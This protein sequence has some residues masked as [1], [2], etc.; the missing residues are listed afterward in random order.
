MTRTMKRTIATVA[1]GV[2]ASVALVPRAALASGFL[3]YDLSGE[4]I[5]R[6]SAVSADTS[7][8]AAVWFNPA[9]LSFQEGASASAGGV[10]V[11]ARSTFTPAEAGASTTDSKRGVFFLPTVF[12]GG[13]VNDRVALGMGIYTA[14]GIGIHWPDDWVGREDAISASLQTLAFN[15]TVAIKLHPQLSIAAGFDAVRATVDFQNGLPSIVGGDVRLVGGTW[16]FGG[17]VAALYRIIPERLHAALTY[18][19]RVKLHFDGNADFSPANP[20][21]DRMLP[22]QPGTASITLPDIFT[23][24][25]MGRVMPNLSLEVDANLTLWQTYN[26]IDIRF[27][28]PATPSRTLLPDGHAALTLRAGADWALARA[29]GLH[30]RAGVIWD[31]SALP[32]DGVGPGLP[33]SNRID[34]TLGVGY[35]RGIFKADLGYMLVTFLGADAKGGH[36]SPPGTYKTTAHLVGLTLAARWGAGA[37]P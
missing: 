36:E 5:G 8:P 13:K 28:N 32:A 12:A 4:A 24:G 2:A 37:R 31:G 25:V 29:P 16:G 20:D 33:D 19:S 9:Q 7:E 14:F 27:S 26:E 35:A 10:L 34:G 22:D 6:A 30:L 17:N 11:T 15:P 1:A 18:R 21:F 3:I 23:A